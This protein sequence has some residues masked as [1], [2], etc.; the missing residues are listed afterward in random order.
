MP[1]ESNKRLKNLIAMGSQE[2]CEEYG[3]GFTD[4]DV[5]ANKQIEC[6]EVICFEVIWIIIKPKLMPVG[7][8]KTLT[9]EKM[10]KR[11]QIFINIALKPVKIYFNT[12]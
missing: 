9:M 10:L 8:T 2:N 12:K 1:E 11:A 6:A 5:G 4:K 7:S 3:Y